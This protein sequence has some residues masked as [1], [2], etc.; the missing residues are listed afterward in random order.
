MCVSVCVSQNES[1]CV[2]INRLVLTCGEVRGW[3][4]G[5]TLEMIDYQRG[6]IVDYE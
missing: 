4:V 2:M 6:T 5:V 3:E 1:D